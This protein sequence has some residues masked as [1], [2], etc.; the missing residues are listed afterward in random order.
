MDPAAGAA[1][2]APG[3]KIRPCA[4][5]PS[6]F[7]REYSCG[8]IVQQASCPAGNGQRAVSELPTIRELSRGGLKCRART[9]TETCGAPQEGSSR[10]RHQD[11]RSSAR[12]RFSRVSFSSTTTSGI[13]ERD[14]AKTASY[15]WCGTF[16]AFALAG[17]AA[18]RCGAVSVV[19]WT[20]VEGAVAANV[21]RL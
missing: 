4:C 20:F 11:R 21:G 5:Y 18:C 13:P 14:R 8:A 9:S 7:A 2:P 10:H 19:P 6:P 17:G 1:A 12:P 3:Q 16:F 15:K